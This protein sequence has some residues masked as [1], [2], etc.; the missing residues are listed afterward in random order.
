M[1]EK[2]QK[3]YF[4]QANVKT[5]ILKSL[6]ELILPYIN[7]S[8]DLHTTLPGI[9]KFSLVLLTMNSGT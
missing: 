8:A 7:V 5:K 3:L 9:S 2:N 4:N 6:E 1:Q